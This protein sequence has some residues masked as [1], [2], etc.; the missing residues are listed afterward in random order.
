MQAERIVRNS[1][2]R[3]QKLLRESAHVNV[4]HRLSPVGPRTHGSR[5]L[6]HEVAIGRRAIRLLIQPESDFDGC[7]PL[8]DLVVDD[9]TAQFG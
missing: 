3:H 7:L 4:L 8:A 1:V 6:G 9:G 2:Q 5:D